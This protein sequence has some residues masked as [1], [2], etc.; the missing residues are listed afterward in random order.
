MATAFAHRPGRGITDEWLTP[1]D[2]LARLGPFDLDP[3]AAVDQPW[4][5][6]ATQWT[7]R[8]DGLSRPWHGRVWLNPPYSNNEAWMR[9]MGQGIALVFART[10]TRWF[11]DTVWDR[12]AAVLFLRGRLHFYTPDGKRAKGNA[13]GPH[14]L[15]AYGNED[16]KT[17]YGLRDLGRIMVGSWRLR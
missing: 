8:D 13:G 7:I 3:C 2:L 16:A 12:A 10:E 5:T 6:A 15:A 17:L 11:F 9:R 4:Q 14:V 1:P